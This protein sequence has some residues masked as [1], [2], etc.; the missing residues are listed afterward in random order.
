MSTATIH[1]P[2]A[3]VTAVRATGH[4][5]AATTRAVLNRISSTM[6]RSTE[7]SRLTESADWDLERRVLD[8]GHGPRGAL[9]RMY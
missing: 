2:N 4:G 5:I 7:D 3:L 1:T 8:L 6:I 9:A